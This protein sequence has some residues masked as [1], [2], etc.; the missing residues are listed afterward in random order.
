MSRSTMM[1]SAAAGMPRKAEPRGELAFV[2]GAALRKLGISGMMHDQ[3][4]EGGGI[5]QRAAHHPRIGDGALAV[6][7][8]DGAGFVQKA[9]LGHHLAGQTLGQR[10]HRLD[11]DE[12]GVARAPPDEIDQR[13]VVDDG[14][15]VGHGDH[16]G[17]AARRGRLARGGQR[18]AMLVR[19]ARR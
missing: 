13:N 18:L 19:R 14:I 7:E 9:D 17:D 8:G 10:G 5:G 2:H 3:R 11:M 16:G 4:V 6:G 1:V 15:G 12:R